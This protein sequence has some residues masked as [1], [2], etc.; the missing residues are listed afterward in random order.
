MKKTNKCMKMGLLAAALLAGVMMGCS[1]VSNS[2]SGDSSGSGDGG[3]GGGDVQINDKYDTVWTLNADFWASG[4]GKYTFVNDGAREWKKSEGITEHTPA[5]EFP[6]EV[7]T[8]VSADSEYSADGEGT[9]YGELEGQEIPVPI[10]EMKVYQ[11]RG[12]NP[13]L[14][15]EEEKSYYNAD[16]VRNFRFY[17]FKGKAMYDLDNFIITVDTAT[18]LVYAYAEIKAFGSMFG[19]NIPTAFAAVETNAEKNPEKTPFYEFDPIGYVN[20]DG[21]VTLYKEY[22]NEITAAG[23][24]YFPSVH[25]TT[26]LDEAEKKADGF[27]RSPYYTK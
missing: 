24:D 5:T 4:L 6:T 23:V 17:R 7:K 3:Q 12:D 16:I 10:E 13:L 2:G 21:I 15:A 19:A 11:Y 1:N 8:E 14:T 9:S 20:D 22:Q 26:G 27:G 25:T 18:D